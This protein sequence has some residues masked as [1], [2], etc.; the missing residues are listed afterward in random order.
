MTHDDTD[1]TGGALSV[2]QAIPVGWISSSL[3]A[4]HPLLSN[5]QQP[6]RCQDGQRWEWDGVRFEI[7]HP[8]R[9]S[10]GD[11]SV[12]DNDRGCVL[13]IST[14]AQ[15]VLLA[16][17]IEKASE[18]RLLQAHPDQ[19][20][21]TLLVVPHHGSGTSSTHEFVDAVHPRYAVITAGYRNR[22]GHPKD[23]VV[24]R[25]RAAGSELLRSDDNGAILVDMDGAHF[26]VERYRDVHPRYWQQATAAPPE[27]S[28][29]SR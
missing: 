14:G 21:A 2:L 28:V 1:H 6:V 20:P 23:E 13:R 5:T 18:H 24:E 4:D 9:R 27:R 11:A 7:L 10:Y 29:T 3:S 15:S 19:L 25:Y 17:D 16:A 12:R 22:F 8:S 26:S